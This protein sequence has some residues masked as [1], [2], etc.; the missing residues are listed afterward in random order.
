MSQEA[1]K[2]EFPCHNYPIKV[3]GRGADDYATTVFELVRVHA[4]ECDFSK[5][6]VRDSSKG[7]FCSITLYITATGIEQ[8]QHLHA[9]LMAHQYVHM[10]I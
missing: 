6:Q 4:P 5:A 8:L 3:V 10:V 2:I 9:D 1:P 7:N